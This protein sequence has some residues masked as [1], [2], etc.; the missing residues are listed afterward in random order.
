MVRTKL[1]DLLHGEINIKRYSDRE[2]VGIKTLKSAITKHKDSKGLQIWSPNE[3][4][5]GEVMNQEERW[6]HQAGERFQKIY[7]QTKNQKVKDLIDKAEKIHYKLWKEI[8]K[9]E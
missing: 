5:K 9:E 4:S 6:F 3:T 2:S 1:L 7:N 8:T